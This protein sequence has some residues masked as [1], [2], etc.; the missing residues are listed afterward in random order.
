MD[1]KGTQVASGNL[2]VDRR[3]EQLM[4]TGFLL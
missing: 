3:Q 4:K 2:V 1:A